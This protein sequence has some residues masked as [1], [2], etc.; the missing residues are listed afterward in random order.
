MKEL[1][2]GF[3]RIPPNKQR[4]A[5]EALEE[6]GLENSA[7]NRCIW[8]VNRNISEVRAS[9]AVTLYTAKDSKR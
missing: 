3:Q 9:G 4:I 2:P 5:K 1:F 8:T 7:R 6:K